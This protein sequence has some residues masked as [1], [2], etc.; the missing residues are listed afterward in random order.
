MKRILSIQSHVASGY[1]GN[2]AAVFPLQCMGYD[3]MAINTVQFSNHTGYGHWRG[4]VFGADHIREVIEGL[5]ENNALSG[6]DAVLSGYLGDAALGEVILEA[7]ADIAAD[8]PAPVYA[9]DPVMGDVGRGVFVRESI[10]PFFKDR[11]VEKATILTP[12]QFELGLLT[13][14]TVE[15]V[16]D[17]QKACRILHDQG[18]AIV[19]VTSFEHREVKAGTIEML[20]SHAGEGQWR[21]VTPKFAIDPAPNGSGD[22]TSALFLGNLLQDMDVEDALNAT[23]SAV[24]KLFEKT[25]EAGTRELAI[26]GTQD[27]Y[28]IQDP[29][30]RATQIG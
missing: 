19:L 27:Y 2:R 21:I 24:Y 20:A 14:V 18:P 10:P 3:V 17:A 12:N 30:F 7:L 22:V 15:T 28:N 9:C 13:G 11:A 1:V 4:E 26:V 29:D 5:K 8:A 23:A 16:A 25:H 6:V